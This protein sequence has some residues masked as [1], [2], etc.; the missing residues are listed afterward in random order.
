MQQQQNPGAAPAKQSS[1]RALMTRERWIEVARILATGIIAFLY[2][3]Q[4]VPVYVL[5][6]AVAIGLYPLAKRA[7]WNCSKNELWEPRSL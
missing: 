4:W 1:L 7:C 5:W 3:K 6:A 2:W